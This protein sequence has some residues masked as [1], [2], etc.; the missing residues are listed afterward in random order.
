MLVSAPVKPAQREEIRQLAGAAFRSLGCAG[1]ARV[2]FFLE[3]GTERLWINEINTLP[4][5]TSISMYPLLW[6]K[7]GIDVRTLVGRLI[8]LALER[9]AETARNR[10]IL[11][12]AGH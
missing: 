1:L 4:G 3:R 5:F 7:E 11:P 8:E 9:H 12:E 2:D 10:Q 6:G